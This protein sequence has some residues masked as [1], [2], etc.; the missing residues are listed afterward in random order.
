M[1]W[2]AGNG[3][4]GDVQDGMAVRVQLQRADDLSDLRNVVPVEH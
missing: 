2:P 4:N 3:S 1:D